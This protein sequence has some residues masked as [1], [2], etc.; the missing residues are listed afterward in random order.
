MVREEKLHGYE[1]SRRIPD[2]QIIDESGKTRKVFEA[3]R[4][5]N[6]KYHKTRLKEYDNLGIEHH[7]EPLD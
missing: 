2:Q 1:S 4:N 6:S 3:E 7:T 5:P